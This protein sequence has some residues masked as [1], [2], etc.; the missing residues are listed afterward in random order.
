MKYVKYVYLNIFVEG[1]KL[2][3]NYYRKSLI[4]NYYQK[5]LLKIA[6]ENHY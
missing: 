6:I 4:E 2:I 5:S 3:E 1:R